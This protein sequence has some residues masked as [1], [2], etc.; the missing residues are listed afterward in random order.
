MR[1]KWPAEFCSSF[2]T[3]QQRN[4]Q[5]SGAEWKGGDFLEVVLKLGLEERVA[6]GTGS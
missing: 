4:L 3:F 2:H 5:N 6:R 1:L